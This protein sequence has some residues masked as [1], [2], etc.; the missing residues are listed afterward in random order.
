MPVSSSSSSNPRRSGNPATRASAAQSVPSSAPRS[1]LSD[2]SR[3]V[4]FR[5]SKLPPIVIPA[6]VLVLMLVGLGAP[7]LFALPA[8]GVI[9][10]FVAW[11]AYLSWPVLDVRGRLTR[12]FMLLIVIGSA[13]ARTQGWL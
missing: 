4:L 8:L 9:A 11:L 10:L 7:L 5:L 2:R 13:V 3:Q 6:V 12:G 1:A